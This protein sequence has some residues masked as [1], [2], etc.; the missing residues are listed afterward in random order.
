MSIH[1]DAIAI[2]KK[3]DAKDK[4][5]LA[6]LLS[7]EKPYTKALQNA[8]SKF[9]ASKATRKSTKTVDN[10]TDESYTEDTQF[11][12]GGYAK[13]QFSFQYGNFPGEKEGISEAHRFAVWWAS[14][15]NVEY[16][17]HRLISYHDDW[18]LVEKYYDADNSYK[19]IE[20]IKNGEYG[21]YEKRIERE[22]TRK[23]G[24]SADSGIIYYASDGNAEQSSYSNEIK[25]KQTEISISEMVERERTGRENSGN[26]ISDS[27]SSNRDIKDGIDFSISL[28]NESDLDINRRKIYESEWRGVQQ[29]TEDIFRRYDSVDY[30]INNPKNIQEG[31][32]NNT[33]NG[34]FGRGSGSETE[35]TTGDHSA[36]DGTTEITNNDGATETESPKFSIGKKDSQGNTLSEKQRE[37]FKNS[38]VVDENGNLLV[39][40]HGTPNAGFTVF[41]S[42]PY[43]TQNKE[44]AERYKN[45]GASSLGYKKEAKNP[46]VYS[47]YLNITKPFDTRNK[48]ER[49]IFDKEYFGQWGTGTPLMESGLPD[50]MDG[51]DLVD[52]LQE[53]GYDYDG[54]ILDEGSTGGYG[55]E[56]KSRGLSYVPFES[57]QIKNID[58]KNPTTHSDIRFS[59]GDKNV[60]DNEYS[61]EF[62]V[63]KPDMMITE[64]NRIQ[65]YDR[66]TII[67]MA[68]NNA[69]RYGKIQEDGS[70]SVKVN[71]INSDVIVS[72]NGIKHSLTRNTNNIAMISC[73]IGSILQKSIRINELE[74]VRKNANSAYILI[75]VAKDEANLY[76]VRSIINKYSNELKD[77]DVLYAI[78]TKKEAAVPKEPMA[79]NHGTAS[80]ITIAQ[81]LEYVNKYYPD[82]LPKWVRQI[83]S[84][85]FLRWNSF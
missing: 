3:H 33:G 35:R 75:G 85:F 71:D 31:R 5:E 80:K 38:K 18:Y 42:A 81:L 19:V 57:N 9:V 56:I 83:Q 79:F 64:L 49:T 67:E 12:K 44:Y 40:Y 37:Y 58:N 60:K 55:E 69:K 34:Q 68:K 65:E 48:K 1:A 41:K 45:Q 26:G 15:K 78:N 77:I 50:W 59:L 63:S 61:Y 51:R 4:G 21:E 27:T 76:I 32:R 70:V 52:F 20:K 43:F 54:I 28:Y 74:G 14:N 47:V 73:S 23:Y 39:M 72:T 10:V 66:K 11:R 30:V 62:F 53:K 16:G 46:D 7:A 8:G 13:K 36:E 17:D 2:F 25:N 29:E 24:R 22:Y 6:I 82:I 84:Y